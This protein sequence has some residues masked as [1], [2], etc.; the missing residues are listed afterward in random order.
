MT[1][2]A[3]IVAASVVQ[4]V[5]SGWE[6]ETSEARFIV[7]S[8]EMA[9]FA[10]S[11]LTPAAQS[12]T[13]FVDDGSGPLAFGL[14]VIDLRRFCAE[15]AREKPVILATDK[16]NC[17]AALLGIRQSHILDVREFYFSC[18][19][20]AVAECRPHSKLLV[21]STIPRSGTFR[22]RYFLFALNEVL[23]GRSTEL[24][25]HK[26]FLY[27]TSDWSCPESPYYLAH[28][29]R[30][31]RTDAIQSGHFVPPGALSALSVNAS[32]AR[33]YAARAARFAKTCRQFPE[34][35]VVSHP[36]RPWRIEPSF[37][38][39]GSFVETR[40]ALVGR[41]ILDQ[42]I[43]MLTYYELMVPICR[44]N[45]AH[46]WSI[47]KF[48]E[49]CFNKCRAFVF[50]GLDGTV[51]VILYRAVR[52][53]ESVTDIVIESGVVDSLIVDYAL[54]A[55]AL[56]RSQKQPSLRLV[57]K[58]FSYDDMIDH[59]EQF[60]NKFV[61]FLRGAELDA[62][63]RKVVANA[64]R[65]TN[66]QELRKAESILGHSLS[67][68]NGLEGV[69][70][71]DTHM[72]DVYQEHPDIGAIRTAVRSKVMRHGKLILRRFLGLMKAFERDEC[73]QS[74]ISPPTVDGS[75]AEDAKM[76]SHPNYQ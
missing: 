23:Q 76:D 73:E 48:I 3:A 5:L 8:G 9:K 54:Q 64:C 37:R 22:I 74:T 42:M 57:A 2:H 32:V 28:V 18:Q 27:R 47:E 52:L 20:R 70:R 63:D 11:Y 43:S 46:R 33:A 7:G 24:T 6:L 15:V 16:G 69:F 71:S 1:G 72:T 13:T 19:Y 4:P 68:A 62:A 75:T 60:F 12:R 39:D 44:N 51:P 53:R 36:I 40:Y 34:L 61:S 66:K 17:L 45:G 21:I 56:E 49:L 29:M 41:N 67:F 65:V 30:F 26:L 35:G 10:L 38:Y 14:P 25:P 50:S 55:F 59:E 31:L 58:A